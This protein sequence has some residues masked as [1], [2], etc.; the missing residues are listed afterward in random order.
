MERHN[1]LTLQAVSD[2]GVCMPKRRFDEMADLLRNDKSIEKF[3]N[4]PFY[5]HFKYEGVNAW[6]FADKGNVFT[7]WQC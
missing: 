5:I 1:I 2:L 3:T 7:L 4:T 6:F